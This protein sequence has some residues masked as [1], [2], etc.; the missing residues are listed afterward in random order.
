[1]GLGVLADRRMFPSAAAIKTGKYTVWVRLQGADADSF[2]CAAY[3][4]VHAA[5]KIGSYRQQPDLPRRRQEK[6]GLLSVMTLMLGV[7]A[8]GM[9]WCPPKGSGW[10]CARRRV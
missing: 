2:I 4:P 5:Q 6:G 7:G 10:L 3:A 1:M 8:M 9:Q